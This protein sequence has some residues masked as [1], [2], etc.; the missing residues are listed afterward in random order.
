MKLFNNMKNTKLTIAGKIVDIFSETIF[1]G[2][3][4]VENGKIVEIIKTVKEYRNYIMPGFVD[5]HVHIESSM[6]VPS[7]FAKL[8]VRN[9]TV[10]TV[11]DPH[12]IANVLGIDGVDFM[13]KNGKTVPFKFYFGA[14]SCV[15][16]TSFE[17]SG[18]KLNSNDVRKLLQ[19]KDI[20]YLSEV[21]N[22]PG[23]IY[24]DNDVLE[25][26]KLAVKYNKPVDGHA[27]GLSNSDLKKY[28]QAGITTD[29]ESSTLDEAIEKIKLGIKLLIREGSAAKNFTA[30]YKAIDLYPKEVML[31]TDDLHPDDLISNHI[32]YLVK[33]GVLFDV[34][35]F[36]ILKAATLNPVVHYNLDV[37]LLQKGDFADFIVVEDLRSFKILQTYINGELVFDKGNVLI[38]SSESLSPNN[39]NCSKIDEE[40]IKIEAKSNFIN[41]IEAFDGE[42]LTKKIVT[43]VK[44]INGFIES[45]TKKDILKIVVLNRYNKNSKPVVGF[46]NSFG[47][48][49]GAI[50]SSIAHDSHNIIAVGVSDKDITNAI[51]TLIDNKGGIVVANEKEIDSLVLEVAGLMTNKDGILVAA[52]YKELNKKVKKLGTKLNSPFMTL[53]FM[54]L[55]VIPELKIGDKGL[56]DVEIFKPIPLFVD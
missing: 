3:I 36:N 26:I 10:A 54:A 21:M 31:C 55:L 17:T 12:E 56:F 45:N 9:G 25:K 43:K 44:P 20:H 30:L 11:S 23:V 49:K 19:R 18:A 29:H 51:N 28:A 2:E 16:A 33:K 37:G 47:L 24:E 5:A 35:I 8:A 6:L 22:F 34:N 40:D 46:I 39:F 38:K 41:L 27:P 1:N 53:S 14:P 42:L 4:I 15:P 50:A 32:N 13:I 7:E 48:K 52:K